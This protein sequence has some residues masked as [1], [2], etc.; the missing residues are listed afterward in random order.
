MRNKIK[1]EPEAT[2]L[3][4]A[5]MMHYK[6]TIENLNTHTHAHTQNLG[7]ATFLLD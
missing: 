7:L 4:Y 2:P 6:T 3:V 5:S 1:V